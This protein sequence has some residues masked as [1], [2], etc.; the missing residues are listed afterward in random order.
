MNAR[1]Q[2]LAHRD[3][4]APPGNAIRLSSGSTLLNLACTG[5]PGGAFCPGYYY[6][7]V[8]DSMSGKTWLS[9]SCFAEAARHPFFA[10]YQFVYDDVEQ[11]AVQ[12]DIP[13]YFGEQCAARIRPPRLVRGQPVYSDT[14]ESFYHHIWHYL[15][16]K[17]PVLYI[18]DSQ[19]A[20]TSSAALDKFSLESKAWRKGESVAGSYS[21]GKAKYHSE[22]IRMV[23]SR[24]RQTGSILLIIGQ[25]RDNLGWGWEKKTRAGGRALRF[26][27]SLEIWTSM[28][29]KITKTVRGRSRTLG[30]RCL[31]EIKKNR[32]TGRIGSDRSVEI[33]IYYGMGIDDVGSCVDFLVK[34]GYWKKRGAKILAEDFLRA[35]S[36]ER[37]I[38]YI[39]QEALEPKV[40]GLVA[41]LWKELDE[42]CTPKRKARY[43]YTPPIDR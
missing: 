24:L 18:L 21:D 28:V 3:R 12:I 4:P 27:A 9:L 31:A 30:I 37:L 2:L 36:R 34:E 1:E 5:D 17:H 42:A 13:R 6:Y 29:G 32:A 16:G 26:Y 23:I 41:N 22:H 8:G 11:G 19:D 38:Q 20:L 14:V 7:L 39:E 43:D 40:Q 35:D 15:N 25:T 10:S 33:P